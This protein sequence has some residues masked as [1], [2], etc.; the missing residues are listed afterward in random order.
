MNCF[1]LEDFLLN[2]QQAKINFCCWKDLARKKMD[3]TGCWKIEQPLNKFPL[4]FPKIVWKI[5]ESNKLFKIYLN[6][7]YVKLPCILFLEL[8]KLA[9]IC[10]LVIHN[11][12]TLNTLR[13]YTN[14]W[15]IE[16]RNSQ[17]SC[18]V[19]H[20]PNSKGPGP[21]P[22]VLGKKHWPYLRLW[23]WN[24]ILKRI[25]LKIV[26]QNFTNIK[27]SFPNYLNLWT[28]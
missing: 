26:V 11:L 9:F 19:V 27:C 6:I 16:M 23:Y 17:I 4:K 1:S 21:S 28:L 13:S 18:F 5:F 15:Y 25:L 7:F 12:N 22:K 8:T 3:L 20:F 24:I 2:L 10:C 14:V